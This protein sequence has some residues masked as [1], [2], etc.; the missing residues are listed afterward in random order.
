MKKIIT[1]LAI[2]TGF[3]STL[4]AQTALP[5]LDMESG[6]RNTEIANCW[7][8]TNVAYSNL[9]FRIAGF[10]SGRTTQLTS[11]STT[12]AFIKSPWLTI[13]SGNIT[14]KTRLENASG[15]S[16]AVVFSY[17]PYDVNSLNAN[18]EGSATIFYTYN[19]ATPLDIWLKN[20]SAP[21]PSAIANS[22]KPYKIMISFI[23]SGGT[24]RAF[25]D[26]LLIPSNYNSNPANSCLPLVTVS[27]KDKDGVEDNL[28]AYPEDSER[29]YNTHLVQEATL[30]FED[31]WPNTGD[32]DFNDLVA[33]YNAVAVTN[34]SNAVVE[35]LLDVQLRAIGAS[36]NNG[37]AFQFDNLDPLKIKGVKGNDI[38]KTKWVSLNENG[39][40]SEQKFANIIVFAESHKILQS[41]GGSGVNVIQD[42]PYVK[43][44]TI[45]VIIT[46]DP[47]KENAVSTKELVLNPYIIVNQERGVEVHLANNMPSSKASEKL[48]GTGKD[49]TSLEKENY[50][51]TENNLPFAIQLEKEAPHMLEKNDFLLGYP[52]FADWIKSDGKEYTDWYSNA[53]YRNAKY[54]YNMKD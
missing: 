44:Q 29:A 37:L 32:Y 17:I 26:D 53:E 34:A 2:V 35:V 43:P 38:E 18:K 50:Y 46:F 36:F 25:V 54:L 30:M 4:M 16:K 19:F 39:T 22:N 42:N 33:K 8:F 47:S 21:I 40:E 51:K 12:N 52:K 20:V 7:G 24:S 5:I 45:N 1:S 10:W 6:N 11:L 14:L 13:G 48:F 23:G 31:L 28:D 27:D 3:F 41:S 49:R 15:T 9:E